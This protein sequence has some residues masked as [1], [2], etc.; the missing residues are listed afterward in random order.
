LVTLVPMK[1]RKCKLQRKLLE[2]MMIDEDHH[3]F[4]KRKINKKC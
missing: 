2:L 4:I 1:G 3:A